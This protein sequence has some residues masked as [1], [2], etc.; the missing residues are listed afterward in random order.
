MNKKIILIEFIVSV[1]IIIVFTAIITLICWN[2]KK[3]IQISIKNEE[4]YNIATN[5]IENIKS[6]TYED[7][8]E[9]IQNFSGVGVS[10][11]LDEKNQNISIEGNQFNDTFFGTVIPNGY[12]L[13]FNIYIENENYDTEKNIEI[14]LKYE[15]LNKEENFKFTTF[16]EKEE[17]DECNAPI[18][19]D[20]YISDLGFNTYEYE[21][22]PI[23]YSESEKNFVVTTLLDK[24]WYNYSSKKW[25][26]ILIFSRYGDNL[27]D[28]FIDEN[29]VVKNTINY[30]NI[31]LS[32]TDY[33]YVWI[34][35][36]SIKDN[37]SYFRYG[38]SKKTIKLDFRNYNKNNFYL[39]K[40]S[41]DAPDISEECNFDGIYGVWK[42]LN[43]MQDPYY[44]SFCN[45]KY[46]PIDLY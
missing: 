26:K 19:N 41:E 33:I 4:S 43:D 34:P 7:V 1:F 21:I 10:K 27:K 39:Y 45:T 25:A 9:Y 11:K 32:L 5:I 35:N 46:A 17:I 38:S 20:S 28:L 44:K 23:K 30:G 15:I 8:N 31:T 37:I 42:K 36:F 14:N 3:Q 22:I 18:I 6:R 12:T 13:E 29:G 2:M 40:I 24:E 16:L